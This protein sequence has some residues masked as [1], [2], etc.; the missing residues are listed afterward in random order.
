MNILFIY[1]LYNIATTRKPLITPET[2]QFGISYISSFLKRHGHSTRLMVLSRISG[3]KNENMI[4]EYIEKFK[5]GLICFTAVSSEY[6]FISNLAR[7]IKNRFPEIY[8]VIGGAHVSLNPEGVLDNFDALCIGEGENPTLELVSQLGKSIRPSGI[9]NLWIKQGTMIEKNPPRPYL[10]N[11]DVFPFPDR[12]MWQEWIDES[13]STRYAVMLGR[14]CPFECTYCCNHALKKLSSGTYTRYRSPDNIVS[15]LKELIIRF[16][17]KKEIYL[18]VETIGMKKDWTLELCRKLEEF[19]STL[20]QPLSFG[21]NIRIMPN[22]DLKTIFDAFKRAN[23]RFINIGLESGSE[24]IRREI[25][26]RNY[27]NNDII[28]AVKLAREYGLQVSFLNMVGLPGETME[29]FEKTIEINRK[30]L[31][32]WT[33][34]SIFYPYPGTDL[35]SL[36]KKQELLNKSIDNTMERGKAVLNLPG[37]SK[38]E[39]EKSQIWFEYNIYKGYRPSVRLL[40][41]V[42]KLKMKTKPYLYYTYKKLKNIFIS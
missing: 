19:N 37:F 22:L 34:A 2:I 20:E 24:K 11:L 21:A 10:Q 17:A 38:K 28:N 4:N 35:Y 41:N 8:L 39:I 1:S 29:D 42:F 12:E 14:G 7:Y 25:L 36:C 3:K 5:P 27:S 30:C 33:S 9:P 16:H 31:P 40:L 15:E 6:E 18:E 23:F 26:N 32:D 13:P